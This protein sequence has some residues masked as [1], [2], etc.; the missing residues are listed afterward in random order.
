MTQQTISSVAD[1][2]DPERGQVYESSRTGER[3]Q[4]LYVDEQTALLRS[5]TTGRNGQNNHR[6]LIRA[7][8]DKNVEHGKFSYQP[9]SNL[10]LISKQEIDWSQIRHIGAKTTENLYD[11]GIETAVD[12]QQAT[13]DELLSIDGVGSAGL[14]NLRDFI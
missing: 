6:I 13:D 11:A 5:E 7:D 14:R 1:R 2:I 3:C 8:F 10:D 12:L 9:E 4:L